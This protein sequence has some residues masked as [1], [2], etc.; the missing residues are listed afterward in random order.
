[1]IV[2]SGK[3]I[4]HR[5]NILNAVRRQA[6]MVI[7]RQQ[8]KSTLEVGYLSSSPWNLLELSTLGT[9]AGYRNVERRLRDGGRFEARR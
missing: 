2:S 3:H 8:T 9:L 6:L 7:L 1:M 5:N 4:P